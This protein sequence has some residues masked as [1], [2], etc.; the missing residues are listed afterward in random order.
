MSTPDA[1]ARFEALY[2][3]TRVP[4]LGYLSR[5]TA[6]L[7]DAA[8]LL[9]EVYLVAWRRIADV[10][11]GD[12]ARLWLFGVAR[13]VL[14][15]Y[16]RR[17]RTEARLAGALQESLRL[18][19]ETVPGP[20][21]RAELVSAAMAKL[22]AADREVLTLAAWEEL[23]PAE[24]ARVIGRPAAVVRVRLHRARQR[25]GELLEKA[26]EDPPTA[27]EAAPAPLVG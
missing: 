7:E 26:I 11:A 12:E 8:D 20:D 5:R 3:A 25:L 13:R 21:P 6:S 10:P 19:A 17:S 27:V 16:H 18:L 4:V 1:S 2:R 24:I 14:A 22:S 23:T 15:N 9:A